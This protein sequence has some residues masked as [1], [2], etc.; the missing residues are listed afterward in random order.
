MFKILGII[1]FIA[2]LLDFFHGNILFGIIEVALGIYFLK[3]V[4]RFRPW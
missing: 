4:D 2:G 1:I 3:Y